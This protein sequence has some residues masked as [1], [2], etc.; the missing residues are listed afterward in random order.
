MQFMR[1]NWLS[2]FQII[3]RS[4]RPYRRGKAWNKLVNQP[5][6]IMSL[7]LCCCHELRL[8]DW[9]RGPRLQRRN[10]LPIRAILF[11]KDGT[12]VEFDRTWGPAVQVV[13]RHLA[14]GDAALYRSFPQR[15][16]LSTAHTF[17]PTLR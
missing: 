14:G 10:G 16:A 8:T 1:D 15:A 5:W 4:R 17:G 6:R 12:L 9:I 2:T 13:L 7:A 3:R 11:D